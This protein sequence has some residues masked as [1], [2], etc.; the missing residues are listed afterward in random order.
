MFK[1][2]LVAYTA[3]VH[4]YTTR[5]L[6]FGEDKLSA[7]SGILSALVKPFPGSS[8]GGLPEYFLDYALLWV[9]IRPQSIQVPGRGRVRQFL[10]WSWAGWYGSKSYYNGPLYLNDFRQKGFD[11]GDRIPETHLVMELKA[12]GTSYQTPI[13]P[14]ARITDGTIPSTESIRATIPTGH[15]VL[16]FSAEVAS[17]QNV[18]LAGLNLRTGT[19]AIRIRAQD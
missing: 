8:M 2:R 19:T 12:M 13:R 4:R 11:M 1:L 18:L 9:A 6:S 5:N 7:F 15:E 3:L 17:V 10:S 14:L 16:H